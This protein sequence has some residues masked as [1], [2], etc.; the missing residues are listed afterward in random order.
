[1]LSFSVT[2]ATLHILMLVAKMVDSVNIH[3]SLREFCCRVLVWTVCGNEN[4]SRKK[5]VLT[6]GRDMKW[7]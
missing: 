4:P 2:L 5:L 6:D 3:I 7:K 1:M